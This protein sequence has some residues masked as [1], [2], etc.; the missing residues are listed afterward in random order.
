LLFKG[1][2]RLHVEVELSP[3]ERGP[4]RWPALAKINDGRV[5][6]CA[7]TVAVREALV[8]QAGGSGFAADLETLLPQ[9]Y[10]SM[11]EASPLWSRTW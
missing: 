2:E 9:K 4:K 5:A 8:K 6:L 1:G 11:T 10:L 7:G 3:K